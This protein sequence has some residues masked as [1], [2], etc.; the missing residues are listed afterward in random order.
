MLSREPVRY[1]INGV[2]ATLVNYGML[3]FNMLILGMK[4]AGAASFLATIFGIMASFLG[5]RYFV[6]RHHS[7]T[8]SSQIIRF[9]LLYGFIAIVSGL[10]LY[11][12][13]D[14]YGFSYH[15]GFIVAT[16][17]QVLFSYV[18]NREFVF[19]YEN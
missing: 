15:L 3:N 4:S 12:W 14:L 19:K 2:V 18:G 16:F 9:I 5:S 1:I 10:V 11:V 8:V 13:S 7:N 6:Y 17:I